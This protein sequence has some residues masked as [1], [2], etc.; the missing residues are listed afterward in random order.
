MICGICD[1]YKE[2]NCFRRQTSS[3][4]G[5]QSICKE[6]SKEKDKEYRSNRVDKIKSYYQ[7]NK[8]SLQE[9]QKKY[10]KENKEK[11]RES[12]RLYVSK[13]KS[14]IQEN[15]KEYRINNKDSLKEWQ[16]S[17]RARNIK[18]LKIKKKNYYEDNINIISSKQA[19][20]YQNN[21]KSISKKQNKYNK[22]RRKKDPS[23]RILANLRRRLIHAIKIKDISKSKKTLEY[24]G[25]SSEHL[26]EHLE[27]KFYN[28]PETNTKMTWENYG[29]GYN[30]WQLDHIIEFRSVDLSDIGAIEKVMCYTNTQPLWYL[31]HKIK[32]KLNN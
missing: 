13:N 10:R 29:L 19:I 5:Y 14:T 21:K 32:T 11:V 1:L 28:H 3:K 15:Q 7:K 4:T 2:N 26:R 22:R 18:K 23:F 12:N 25:C 6:C 30:K 24:I 20:Y 27:K 17:Y 16:H 8:N 31:D 9:K